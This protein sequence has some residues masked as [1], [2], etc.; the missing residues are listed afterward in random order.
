MNETYNICLTKTKEG[1]TA[2]VKELE[3]VVH[4]VTWQDA[5]HATEEAIVARMYQQSVRAHTR[6]VPQVLRP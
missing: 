3:I 6:H 4:G 2:T 1:Y 5:L